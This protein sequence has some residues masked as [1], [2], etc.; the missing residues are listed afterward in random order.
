MGVNILDVLSFEQLRLVIVVYSSAL[1]PLV[2][3]PILHWR[4]RI[5]HWVLGFYVKVFLLCAL[6]WEI[7]FNYGIWHGD[8]VSD[9]RADILNKII[10][11]DVNWLLNSLADAGTVVCGGLLLVWL[12]YRRSG[13]IYRHWDWQVFSVLLLFFVAQN[14]F[15]ELFLYHDQLAQGKQLSWAPLSPGGPWFNPLLG[16]IGHRTLMFNTQLP[17]MLV[18]PIVYRLLIRS[19]TRCATY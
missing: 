1:V 3:I 18:T 19:V 15:V 7:W 11:P 9:R 2:V 10:P 14:V 8:P 17:W 4:E 13:S 6:G 5:P 16:Q 12:L